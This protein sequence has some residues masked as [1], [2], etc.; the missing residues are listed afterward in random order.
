M[1]PLGH[2][3]ASDWEQLIGARDEERAPRAAFA[4]WRRRDECSTP[5]NAPSHL[6]TPQ[7]TRTVFRKRGQQ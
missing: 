2:R 5:A 1:S 4:G 7:E 3:S 6:R